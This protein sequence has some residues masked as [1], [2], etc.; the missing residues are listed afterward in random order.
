MRDIH[1]RETH[2]QDIAA[3]Q[4]LYPAAFPDEDLLPLVG[5]LLDEVPGLIS[6]GAFLRESLIGHVIFTPCA[7]D[8]GADAKLSVLGPLAVAPASQ[9]QGIGT[10]LLREGLDRLKSGGISQVFVLGDPAYYGRSGFR[11]ATNIAPPYP[12]PDEYRDAWQSLSLDAAPHPAP[13]TLTVPAPWRD[14]ALWGP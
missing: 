4:A 11:P 10:A 2:P 7:S 14:P 1:I 8:A 9:R 13:A 12:L 3:I 5:R 6:L